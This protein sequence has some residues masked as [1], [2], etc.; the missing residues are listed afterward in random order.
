MFQTPSNLKIL[1]EALSD[2]M[3]MSEH[4]L[5]LHAIFDGE[6]IFARDVVQL[7]LDMP[8]FPVDFE[9]VWIWIR[10]QLVGSPQQQTFVYQLEFGV[11]DEEDPAMQKLVEITQEAPLT[12]WTIDLA[13]Q[14]TPEE[15][16]RFVVVSVPDKKR[17]NEFRELYHG[18][19]VTV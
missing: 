9:N 14:E 16:K 11:E 8:P 15:G 3:D 17:A 12:V 10:E 19:E 2:H 18:R 5:G 6:I 13:H 4:F 1:R 7:N